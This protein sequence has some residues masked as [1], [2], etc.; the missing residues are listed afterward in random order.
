M[1]S[2]NYAPLSEET[3]DDLSVCCKAYCS[4]L[5][6]FSIITLPVTITC[7]ISYIN[8]GPCDKI[9]VLN[10][11]NQTFGIAS[12]D[13]DTTIKWDYHGNNPLFPGQEGKF[14]NDIIYPQ[15]HGHFTFEGNGSSYAFRIFETIKHN[16]VTLSPSGNTMNDLI[17]YKESQCEYTIIESSPTSH[18]LRGS[19]MSYNAYESSKTSFNLHANIDFV[20]RYL[21]ILTQNLSKQKPTI[22]QI[23]APA[24]NMF[25]NNT[26]LIAPQDKLQ[27]KSQE[28]STT[29]RISYNSAVKS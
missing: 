17:L 5:C 3:C 29:R 13:D 8:A 27:D 28:L 6:V 10:N 14:V 9:S 15:F 12:Q 23:S 21:H 18:Y 1:P 25:K 16:R 7:A 4:L 26:L 24:S 2:N 22:Q 19:T 11:T 20:A